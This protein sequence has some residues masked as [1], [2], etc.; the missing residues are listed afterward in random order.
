MQI[1][2]VQNGIILYALTKMRRS[3]LMENLDNK[4]TPA[5]TPKNKIDWNKKIKET[6]TENIVVIIFVARAL[7]VYRLL[8]CL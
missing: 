7:P 6:L 3:R 8:R 5:Q 2:T 1:I 4:I